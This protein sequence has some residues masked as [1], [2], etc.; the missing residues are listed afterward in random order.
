MQLEWRDEAELDL[1]EILSYIAERNFQAAGQLKESI[2][3]AIEHLAEHP[4]LY[5]PSLR[6]LGWREIVVQP[7]YIVFYKVTDKV[8]IMAVAHSRQMYPS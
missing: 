4:Y 8:Y 6:M 2:E 5:K 1:F 3:R 7:N